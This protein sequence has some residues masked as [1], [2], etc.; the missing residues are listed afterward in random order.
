LILTLKNCF[1]ER[2]ILVPDFRLACPGGITT[3]GYHVAPTATSPT[4]A[5]AMSMSIS[6]TALAN[7]TKSAQ[8]PISHNP[9]FLTG[10]AKRLRGTATPI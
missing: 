1:F 2:V 7:G 6:K 3:G 10:Q 4:E 8:T 5:D 9:K